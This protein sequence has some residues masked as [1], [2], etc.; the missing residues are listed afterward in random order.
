MYILYVEMG[1]FANDLIINLNVI[2]GSE[3]V[4]IKPINYTLFVIQYFRYNCS[5]YI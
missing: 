1:Y 5:G 2:P 4:K 3:P